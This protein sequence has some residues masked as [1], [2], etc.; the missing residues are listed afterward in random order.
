[1][2]LTRA[3][4][5]CLVSAFPA[6]ASDNRLIASVKAARARSLSAA[7]APDPNCHSGV[8]S[9]K[10]AGEPQACCESD[11]L[12]MACGKA[13]ANVCLKKCTE[14]VPPCIMEEGKTFKKP[15]PD[16]RNA[17]QDCNE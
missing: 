5:L 8:I 15:D 10:V 16:A 1:M 4:L 7:G 3:V 13:P 2:K 12:K 9:L 14:S 11:V 17:G 6:A